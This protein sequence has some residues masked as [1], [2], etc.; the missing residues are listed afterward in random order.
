[1]TISVI[2]IYTVDDYILTFRYGSQILNAEGNF[3]RT[4]SA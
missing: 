2:E 3:Q 4:K 1:M